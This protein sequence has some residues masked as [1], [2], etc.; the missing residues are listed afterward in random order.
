MEYVNKFDSFELPSGK[1][2]VVV[3]TFVDNGENFAY[4]INTENPKEHEF[5]VVTKEGE[6]IRVDI[7]DKEA[8]DNKEIIDKIKY[9][10]A[11][12]MLKF[13]IEKGVINDEE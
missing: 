8:E 6:D 13:A 10:T 12:D 7:L 11:E 1:K 3:Y 2:Y 9:R 4:L 5:A